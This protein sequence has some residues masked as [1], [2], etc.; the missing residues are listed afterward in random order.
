MTKRKLDREEIRRQHEAAQKE[1]NE[2]RKLIDDLRAQGKKV[3]YA[4]IGRMYNLTRQRIEQIDK[5]R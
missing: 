4:E 3:N 2:I 5:N 1:N